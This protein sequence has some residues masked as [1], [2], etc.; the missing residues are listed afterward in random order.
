MLHAIPAIEE[1]SMT[2]NAARLQ[3]LAK[4]LKAAGLTRVNIS[5]DTL[6]REKMMAISRRAL[7]DDVMA[8]IEAAIE[9]GLTPLKFNCVAMRGVNDDEFCDLRA[10]SV[11]KLKEYLVLTIIWRLLFLRKCTFPRSGFCSS[12]V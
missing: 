1:I 8:G 10:S 5:L 3:D 12:W 4:P 11:A 2:T 9:S 6:Q 7:Y